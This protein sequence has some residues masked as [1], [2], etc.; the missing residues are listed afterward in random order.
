LAE[1]LLSGSSFPANWIG[2]NIIHDTPGPV[3]DTRGDFREIHADIRFQST[4][5]STG[6]FLWS[7]IYRKNNKKHHRNI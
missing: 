2:P 7:F 6:A 5:G 3:H 4:R 1:Q